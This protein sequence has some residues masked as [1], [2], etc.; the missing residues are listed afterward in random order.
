[1]LDEIIL[2]DILHITKFITDSTVHKEKE[3]LPT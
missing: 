3:Q 2:K 1:M